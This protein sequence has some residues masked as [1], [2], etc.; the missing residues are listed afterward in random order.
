MSRAS[1]SP[2]L[3]ATSHSPQGVGVPVLGRAAQHTATRCGSAAGGALGPGLGQFKG[4]EYQRMIIAGLSDGL[5]PRD[6]VNR[7]TGQRPRALPPQ[8]AKS[9]ATALRGYDSRTRNLEVF[10]RGNPTPT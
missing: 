1:P 4:L 8:G 7:P 5:A 3:I 2:E 6:A 9:P 10:R